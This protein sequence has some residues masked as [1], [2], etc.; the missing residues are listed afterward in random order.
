VR[1]ANI[2]ELSR[3]CYGSVVRNLSSDEAAYLP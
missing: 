2:G 1:K 3:A